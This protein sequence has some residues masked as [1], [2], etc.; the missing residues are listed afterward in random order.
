MK[1]VSPVSSL[2]Q[3]I[4]DA[5]K[6]HPQ[7]AALL[8]CDSGGRIFRTYTYGDLKEQ[9]ENIASWLQHDLKLEQGDVLGLAMPNSV[10]LLL[11]SWAAWA[12]GIITV[13]FDIKRDTSSQY[14]YKVK[15]TQAKVL[16][17]KGVAFSEK[18][19]R[20]LGR[21]IQI[22]DVNDIDKFPATKRDVTWMNG[23]SHTAL[24]LFTS[25]TTGN[26]KGA[27]LTLE[28]LVSNAQ[29]IKEWFQIKPSDRF[30][31][32]LPLYHINS[33]TFCLSVLLAKGSIAVPPLYSNSYFWQQLAQTQSTFT[34]IVP[35]ICYD[36]LSRTKEFKAV[37]DRL[38]VNRIQIGSAPVVAED[39]KSF[40][41]Q[42]GIPIY[43]GYGQTETALRV[44]GVPFDLNV[45][46]YKQLIEENSIGRAMKWAEVVVVDQ[47]GNT[48]PQ[49]KEGEIA[50]RG[51]IV[52]KGYLN[53]PKANQESFMNGY[54][55]SGD[56]GFWR[57]I[58]DEQY[59]FLKG[60]SKEI[61][62]KGG[63]N[64]SPVAIENKLKQLNKHIDQVYVIGVSDRRY[65]EE[66]GAV[67][68]WKNK[69]GSIPKLEAEFKHQLM[70]APPNI[71]PIEIPKYTTSMKAHELPL[72]STGK[73]QRSVLRAATP[74]EKFQRTNGIAAT[75]QYRFVRLTPDNKPLIPQALAL[76]NYCWS[77][78]VIDE[79]KFIE[80]TR[81]GIV[82]A[83]L[84]PEEKIE[85][86]LSILQTDLSEKELSSMSYRELTG[87]L[88]LNTNK[89]DGDKFICVSVCSSSYAPPKEIANENVSTPSVR[90][91]KRY[92]ESG[93][94]LVYNFHLKPKGNLPR[95]AQLIAILPNSRPED[96]MALG[97]NLLLRYPKIPTRRPVVLHQDE[98]VAVQ[99]L[100]AAM[101]LAQ[102]LGISHIYAFSRPA[103][104]W[105]Y[106][107]KTK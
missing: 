36:Q 58:G 53:N 33:T 13:P 40:M 32:L 79:K 16:F 89:K 37:K 28:N 50:I 66:V 82:I 19:R 84:N 25:G 1:F 55:L 45:D 44:T 67:I 91:M 49:N 39:V 34:S 65:G 23:F 35:T 60:R 70:S 31:A 10:E 56:I 59:F 90:E 76:Y 5:V 29:G 88:T 85:G 52:M 106:F 74:I 24:F 103:G 95:G 75:K 41:K 4:E 62:I 101:I 64:L 87:N 18:E 78:L 27:E 51:P 61:I 11:M 48:L 63:V 6:Y 98:S 73:V 22:V 105:Q 92:L 26:P 107:A 7:S 86:M 46:V 68:C 97:Y 83:A 77:P 8:S 3:H 15:L 80:Q 99:L 38:R 71:M 12:T 94:D 17:I 2:H 100:E 9:M 30:L 43:Q 96:K 104:A 69:S 72:T 102:Q 21:F 14:L 47:K 42:F 54:F 57:Q 81:S 93:K 20:R